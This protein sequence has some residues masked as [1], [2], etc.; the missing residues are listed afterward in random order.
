MVA[1]YQYDGA[2]RRI[3]K[4]F[5]DDTGVEYFYNH[6][7][8]MLE[9]RAVDDEGTATA[10]NQY[11]WSARYIDVPVLRFHDANADGDVLDAV[12]NTHY[13]TGDANYNVTATID[14]VT[15]EVADRYVYTA[16]G[17]ATVCDEDWANPAAPTTDG[18]LYAGY[19][20][21]A[22]TRLYQIRNRYYD[23][24]LSMFISRDP[25]GYEAGDVNL[26]RYVGNLPIHTC[27]PYGLDR[28]M[29]PPP[30]KPYPVIPDIITTPKQYWL[31]VH[32][33]IPNPGP[34]P[35]TATTYCRNGE[36][37]INNKDS[38]VNK[39]CAER[40]EAQHIAD[41]KNRFG[42]NPCKG[43]PD[44]HQPYNEKD[45]ELFHYYTECKAYRVGS[46][47]L[48]SMLC[49][50][51]LSSSEQSEAEQALKGTNERVKD[52]CNKYKEL[53]AQKILDSSWDPMLFPPI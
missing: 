27:D 5:A 44:F 39:P 36:L 40:H 22:E 51:D 12:D 20:F 42:P 18:P 9:E 13:Y 25:I 29:G 50:E 49:Y 30:P 26:Y 3:E 52:N 8:Q 38:S 2:N 23:S 15:G 6:D 28:C 10:V 48:K 16:Y 24:S 31:P 43:V 21:D 37:V 32:D 46:Q 11:V 4:A 17:Q 53:L 1:G 41:F 47:C 7:W 14:A 33:P 35:D 34:D 45:A 19:F